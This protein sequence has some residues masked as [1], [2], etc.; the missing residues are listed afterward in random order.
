MSNQ[1]KHDGKPIHVEFYVPEDVTDGE[2]GTLVDGMKEKVR[3]LAT[4]QECLGY[5]VWATGD[6]CVIRRSGVWE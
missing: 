6:E 5:E 1:P 4:E 2:L 3:E